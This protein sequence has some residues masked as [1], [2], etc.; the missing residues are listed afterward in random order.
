MAGCDVVFHSVYGNSGDEMEQRQTT[1]D[2]TQNT[3]QVAQESGI[4]RLVYLSTMDVYGYPVDGVLDEGAA[5]KY[6]RRFYADTKLDSEKI[7]VDYA[8]CG[9]PISILQPAI[10]Y[11]PFGPNWTV[12]VLD[13]I[14]S[15]WVALVDGGSGY[16]NAVYIDDLVQAM[17]LAAV[18]PRAI[19]GTF[20]ISGEKPSTWA[21]FD[22]AYAH[23]GTRASQPDGPRGDQD[24]QEAAAR[25]AVAATAQTACT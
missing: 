22:G 3:L 11:G 25:A 7:A 15:G 10:V 24:A 19:G 1:V 4:E 13:S 23:V 20:L 14:R 12:H 16:C 21:E 2:G 17:L 6:S 9:V 8:R 18:S 5:R